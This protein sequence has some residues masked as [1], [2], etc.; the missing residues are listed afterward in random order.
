MT[1]AEITVILATCAEVVSKVSRTCPNFNSS[2]EAVK[3]MA[4][5][6]LVHKMIRQHNLKGDEYY[7]LVGQFYQKIVRP[8]TEE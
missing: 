7:D 4:I 8:W 3:I 1:Q 5:T 6:S 2:D